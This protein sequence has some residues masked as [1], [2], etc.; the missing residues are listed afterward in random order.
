MPNLPKLIIKGPIKTSSI[1]GYELFM[2]ANTAPSIRLWSATVREIGN[3]FLVNEFRGDKLPAV[4]V[5]IYDK[6]ET[7]NFQAYSL[8]REIAESYHRDW[9][10]EIEDQSEFKE[11]PNHNS[12]PYTEDELQEE[13]YP[14]GV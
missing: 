7:A 6:R 3:R 13:Y 4:P 1:K 12:R 5:E 2:R 9:G 8:V 11:I 10:L 14:E